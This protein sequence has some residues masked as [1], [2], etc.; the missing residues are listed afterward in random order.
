MIKLQNI[1]NRA[2]RTIYQGKKLSVAELHK[3]DK[4]DTLSEQ[5]DLQLMALMHKHEKMKKSLTTQTE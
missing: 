2:L 4:L 3:K 1:Q 5:M